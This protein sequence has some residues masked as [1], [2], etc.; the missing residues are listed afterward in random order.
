MSAI[1]QEVSMAKKP[2]RTGEPW[3][4]SEVKQLRAEVRQNTPTRVMALKHERTPAAVQKKANKLGLSTKPVN[5]PPY[6]TKNK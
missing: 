2:A 4:A 6:G 1:N 5:Q 3:T